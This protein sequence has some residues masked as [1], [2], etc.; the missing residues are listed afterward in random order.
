[1]IAMKNTKI[2]MLLCAAL[3]LTGCADKKSPSTP[4]KIVVTGTT[5]VS[6]ASDTSQESAPNESAPDE[7]EAPDLSASAESPAE[8]G[9]TAESE[10]TSEASQP[11]PETPDSGEEQTTSSESSTVPEESAVGS[12]NREFFADDLFIGDSISTGLY[13]YDK[14]DWQAVAASVGNTPYKAYSTE[15]EFL[16]GTVMT[17][18][19][20][21]AKRQPKR[22][23]VMLGSNGLASTWDIEGM[24]SNYRTLIEKLREACPDSEIGCISVTPVTADTS[25]TTISNSAVSDFNSYIESMCGEMG[26]SYFDIHSLLADGSGCF[27]QEYAEADGLHFKGLTYDVMLGYIQNE[28][29]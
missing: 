7:S 22:I 11:V 4:S 26:L 2:I 15:I 21:A 29:T 8:S 3:L 20:Y 10:P 5:T 17:P 16:D 28:L 1:M 19:D 27:K 9:E 18:L 6:S 25:Y 24:K 23:F 14:I 13:L 12:Y